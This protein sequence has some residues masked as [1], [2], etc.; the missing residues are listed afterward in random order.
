[1]QLSDSEV[2]A[3]KDVQE[4]VSQIVKQAIPA[5]TIDLAG[6]QSIGLAAPASDIDFRVSLAEYQ[7]DPF[8]RGPSPGRPKACKAA[9]KLLR[10]LERTFTASE[11]FEKT[12]II[13]AIVPILKTT[14]VGAQISVDFKVSYG[15]IPQEFYTALYMAEYPTLRPLYMLLR[16]A[17]HMRDLGTVF[18]GGLGSYPTVI[19]I[20]YAL[21]TCPRNISPTDV[22]SQLLWVLDFYAS[23]NLYEKGFSLTPPAEFSKAHGSY[24]RLH[25]AGHDDLVAQGI[26]RIGRIHRKQPYS[27]CL[28]DPADPNNDLGSRSYGI[29]DVQKLFGWAGTRMRDNMRKMESDDLLAD[30]IWNL[31]GILFPLAGANY[32]DF[33]RRRRRQEQNSVLPMKLD[34]N[35]QTKD[36]IRYR[37]A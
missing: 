15:E 16:S 20:V 24:R 7:R 31:E 37:E 30:K 27:L 25:A 3:S 33:E 34:A 5:T 12:K 21:K 13:N 8:E 32:E 9:M 17:L 26:D 18:Y 4:T 10:E 6:S 36:L 22:G 2:Q 23:A 19:M 14:H 11:A 1:M 28:Q 35:R 29:K